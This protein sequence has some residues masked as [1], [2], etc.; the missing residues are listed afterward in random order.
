MYAALKLCGSFLGLMCSI[1][2]APQSYQDT[3]TAS[4]IHH[5]EVGSDT[6]DNGIPTVN[7]PSGD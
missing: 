3:S 6:T 7:L 1:F 5:Q 4:N 2:Y